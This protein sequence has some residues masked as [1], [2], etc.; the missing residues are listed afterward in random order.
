MKNEFYKGIGKRI[1]ERR[2]EI[3]WT[4]EKLAMKS[5]VSS[6]FLFDIETGQKKMSVEILHKIKNALEVSWNWLIDGVE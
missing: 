3:E 2:V 6:R 1:M 4:R 5:G